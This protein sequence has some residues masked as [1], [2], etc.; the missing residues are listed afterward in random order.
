MRTDCF[1]IVGGEMYLVT[2]CDGQNGIRILDDSLK[3]GSLEIFQV[4]SI[5]CTY[6]LHCIDSGFDRT[7]E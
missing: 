1:G 6:G 7:R 5:T 4:S 2:H 3:G